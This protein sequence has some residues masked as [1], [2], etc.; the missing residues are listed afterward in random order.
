MHHALLHVSQL[1]RTA[2]TMFLN[3]VKR[4]TFRTP[5]AAFSKSDQVIWYQQPIAKN[6]FERFAN[7]G[8]ELFARRRF[9]DALEAY[10][11]AI[12]LHPNDNAVL[13]YKAAALVFLHRY[14][15]AIGV[16][17]LLLLMNPRNRSAW[18]DK[19][20]QLAIIG[21]RD[22]AIQCFDEA[23]AIDPHYAI[24]WYRKG[25]VYLSLNKLKD[26]VESF[27][28]AKL[29]DP[30]NSLVLHDLGSTLA[31]MG[32]F[33]S[34]INAYDMAI[35]LEPHDAVL[36]YNKA[37]VLKDLQQYEQAVYACDQALGV[38]GGK[39]SG[40]K[41]SD[42]DILHPYEG[43]VADVLYIRGCALLNLDRYEEA[44]LSLD[45]VLEINK[46]YPRAWMCKGRALLKLGR[47][48]E[49]INAWDMEGKNE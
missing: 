7:Q 33:E 25:R 34:A 12:V 18:L 5:V 3:S 26:A 38:N 8:N 41:R 16:Y 13:N 19:G 4:R 46:S 10:N 43:S 37:C 44:L 48:E 29:C 30:K 28:E 21:H 39:L 24:S 49:G 32:Q 40:A 23:I 6:E 36:W 45:K 47:L 31:Q 35:A 22:E 2:S 11:K 1:R 42:S 14:E 9:E 20:G 27:E 17:N 15:E